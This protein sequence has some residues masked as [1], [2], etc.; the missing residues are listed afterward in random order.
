MRQSVEKLAQ[1]QT[2]ASP[3]SGKQ[4]DDH[5]HPQKKSAAKNNCHAPQIRRRAAKLRRDGWR[6]QSTRVNILKRPC[7]P[8][9]P[10]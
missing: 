9:T 10:A 5:D 7:T 2:G 1:D 3:V 6:L 4:P 8:S